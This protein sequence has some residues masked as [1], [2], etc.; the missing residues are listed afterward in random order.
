MR[1]LAHPTQ[2]FVW[3]A[4]AQGFMCQRQ[5]RGQSRLGSRFI[6]TWG[7]V[8]SRHQKS[9]YERAQ[10]TSSLE[11]HNPWRSSRSPLL[12]SHRDRLLPTCMRIDESSNTFP[13]T[14]MALVGMPGGRMPWPPPGWPGGGRGGM[15]TSAPPTPCP[16][17][18]RAPESSLISLCSSCLSSNESAAKEVMPPPPFAP[19]ACCC[20]S[21]CWSWLDAGGAAADMPAKGAIPEWDG[22][23]AVLA[24][25]PP[26]AD[27]VAAPWLSAVR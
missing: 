24:P 25:C 22:W 3:I 8:R 19:C 10:K 15:I 12:L 7:E 11:H 21:A 18:G 26:V 20:D 2:R 17:E 13:L 1:C 27:M 16:P 4:R 5:L 9:E 23:A 14:S 6:C